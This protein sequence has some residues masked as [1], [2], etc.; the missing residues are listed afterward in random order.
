MI[1]TSL[2]I[3]AQNRYI[4]SLWKRKKG[5]VRS[6]FWTLLQLEICLFVCCLKKL[7]RFKRRVQTK[8]VSLKV[9]LQFTTSLAIL[10]NLMKHLY[11]EVQQSP[12]HL[13]P[14]VQGTL[15]TSCWCIFGFYDTSVKRP[16][17]EQYLYPNLVLT[18]YG[19]KNWLE[20]ITFLIA[21][22]TYVIGLWHCGSDFEEDWRSINHCI[23][24]TYPPS[25]FGI[26]D[27]WQW[28][29]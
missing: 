27:I 11:P 17:S 6:Q 2:C 23:G 13:R 19:T 14:F 3:W 7:L 22:L 4:F 9:S 18:A 21:N 24:Q 29:S 5:E 20:K 15:W 8:H 16:L 28:S 12:V 26:S 10:Q 25:I 1:K